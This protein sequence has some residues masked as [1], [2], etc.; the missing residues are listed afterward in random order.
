MANQVTASENRPTWSTGTVLPS[1][2]IAAR[3]RAG[4]YYVVLTGIA[5]LFL[6]PSLWM[7]STSLKDAGSIFEYPPKLLPNPILWSNYP[8]AIQKF[9]F[10]LYLRNSVIVTFLATFGTVLSASLVAFGFARRRFPEREALFGVLLST[11]MLPSIV[12]LIPT[13]V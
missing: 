10:W 8:E 2:K 5:L 9:P 6:L 1:R 3:L 4:L 7:I 11:L 13:F 12:T